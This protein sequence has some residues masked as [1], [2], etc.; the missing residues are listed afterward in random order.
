MQ[1]FMIWLGLI[2]AYSIQFLAESRRHRSN[3]YLLVSRGAREIH[4]RLMQIY[5]LLP[6][7]TFFLAAGEYFIKYRL[8]L[9]FSLVSYE[10]QF[11]LPLSFIMIL[12]GALLRIWVIHSLG[13]LWTRRLLACRGFVKTKLGPYRWLS[14]PEYIARLAEGCGFCLLLGSQFSTVFYLISTIGLYIRIIP[15][16]AS[17]LAYYQDEQTV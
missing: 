5:Y 4:S 2:F 10:P 16:E 6:W 12:F 15:K 17:H 1:L 3:Y 7:L 11:F 13:W 14:H 9:S 8:P